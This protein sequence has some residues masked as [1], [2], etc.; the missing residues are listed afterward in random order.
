MQPDENFDVNAAAKD[1]LQKLKGLWNLSYSG[2]AGLVL[3]QAA[4]GLAM[5]STFGM[6]AVLPW[7]GPG[8]LLAGKVWLFGFLGAIC[9]FGG[10]GLGTRLIRTKLDVPDTRGY[11]RTGSTRGR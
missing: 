7:V 10:V 5:L 8:K 9:L 11:A 1:D 6:V 3:E 2:S 4:F